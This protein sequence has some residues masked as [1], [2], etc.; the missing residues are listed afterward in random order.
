LVQV[1]TRLAVFFHFFRLPCHP[2]ALD[3]E[4]CPDGLFV[5][6]ISAARNGNCSFNSAEWSFFED[7]PCHIPVAQLGAMRHRWD[8]V[9]NV[10]PSNICTVLVFGLKYA[11]HKL[12]FS[13]VD[14][15]AR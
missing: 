14:A 2:V 3:I 11:G 9:V 4:N 15:H 8:R 6:L 7:L 5:S 1:R 12:F 10:S 13:P